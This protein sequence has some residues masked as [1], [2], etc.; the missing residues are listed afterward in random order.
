MS[1]LL[2][3]SQ[4][5][6]INMVCRVSPSSDTEIILNS[7]VWIRKSDIYGHDFERRT[8][9]FIVENEIGRLAVGT[10]DRFYGGLKMVVAILEKPTKTYFFTESGMRISARQ[11]TK[12]SSLENNMKTEEENSYGRSEAQV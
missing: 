2:E 3:L 10:V 6:I 4:R 7:G 8:W 11:L 1:N 9:A 5:D 12:G